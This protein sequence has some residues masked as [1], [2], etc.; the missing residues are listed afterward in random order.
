M[1][2]LALTREVSE[3]AAAAAP[4]FLAAPGEQQAWTECFKGEGS[5]LLHL[6]KTASR[7]VSVCPSCCCPGAPTSKR[8]S[9]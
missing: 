8:L 2:L 3:H 5:G 9:T 4:Q 6:Q 1:V 7:C